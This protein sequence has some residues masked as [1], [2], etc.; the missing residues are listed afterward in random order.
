MMGLKASK[1]NEVSET[2]FYEAEGWRVEGCEIE[3]SGG[4]KSK[5]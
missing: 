5:T 3:E 2:S 4:L 1:K